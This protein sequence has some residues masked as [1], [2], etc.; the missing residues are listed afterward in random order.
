M[1]LDG[2]DKQNA[3]TN[4]LPLPVDVVADTAYGQSIT[5]ETVALYY[6]DSGVVTADAGQAAGT[7]VIAK[8]AYSGVMDSLGAMVGN[9]KDTSLAWTTNTVLPIADIQPCKYSEIENPSNATLAQIAADV[10]ANFT[11][12]QWCLDHRNGIIYGKKK[13]TGTSDTAAYKVSTQ[14]VAGGTSVAATV[15]LT[16][17]TDILDVIVQDAAFGTAT[18]GLAVFGKYQATPT[19]YTDGDATPILLDANGRVVL[20]SDIEIGAVELKDGATDTRATI[21]AANTARTTATTVL[22]TQPIDA[23]GNVLGR[24]AANTA[25]TTGTLV[26]PVQV[27]D[28]AGNAV[29]ITAANTARTTGT[30]TLPTQPID[31]AGLVLGRDAANTARTTG[32]KVAPSQLVG[33]D[34]TV[35]PTGSLLTN[36]PFA[37]ITDGTSNL[38]LGT[39]TTKT[40]PSAINDGTTMAT[41]TTGTIKALNVAISDGATIPAVLT[42]T[43][44]TLATSIHDGT[45]LLTL[46]T[47]TK[48]T[49]PVQLSDGTTDQAVIAT[50]QSAKEDISSVGGVAVPAMNAAFGTTTPLVPIAG[51]FMATPTTYD[52][53][54]AVPLALDANGRM[55]LSSDI[56]LGAVEM[57]DGATDAR[58]TIDAANTARTTATTVLATQPIDA[59]GNVLGRTAANVARTTATLVDPVEIVDAAGNVVNITA[60]N[61]ARTT[62][63]LV[64]PTQVVDEAGLVLGRDAANTAR[65]TGTKVAPSQLV[66]A[67]GTVPPT[68]SLLTNAPFAKIT[69]GISNLTL[70]VGTTKTVPAELN[71][72]TTKIIFGTGT[73]KTVPVAISDGTTE[74]DVIA[75]IN[76][77]KA[78]VSSVA[79]TATAVNVG[80]ASAGA[81]RIALARDARGNSIPSDFES[82]QDFAV[83]YTS[84]VT[85]TCSGAS[86]TI[87][88]ANCTVLYVQVKPTGSTWGARYVNGQDGIS[89]IAASNVITIAGAGTPFAASDTYRVGLSAQ[90]K[91]HT[92]ASN[93]TRAEEVNPLSLQVV[94]ES[95]VDT[96]NVAA[97]QQYYPSS[98]GMAMLGYKN[99][100]LTGKY[101]DGDAT[102]TTLIVQGTNDS[103][104][105]NGTWVSIQGQIQGLS[106]TVT[107]TVSGTAGVT[108]NPGSVCTSVVTA[109]A[110]TMTLAWDFDNLN[111][112]YIRVGLL[113]GDATNTVEIFARRSA[114]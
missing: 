4:R 64:L 79:G 25:R 43:T 29:N 32:T 114:M 66:G 24:D 105:T 112:R 5:G 16:D 63:T 34:G 56:E 99:F 11:N 33:A 111:Y 2:Y 85:I 90:K 55:I 89:L 80:V 93:S 67:D 31:E 45:T 82:P 9:D 12:G 91:A 110:Q 94:E 62:A 6:F 100:S 7:V 109:T 49:M 39:G 65:T 95:L 15:K 97:S 17:G 81:Q 35:P 68:G 44:K 76:A 75:T 30:L 70:G 50:I 18:K 14:T 104:A 73:Q 84:N 59:A 37:K 96:T 69:D 78:D 26:N 108:L 46:N 61:T 54:D 13:T 53:G 74:V 103:D 113:P 92:A 88:D 8:L 51:K 47:G 101:I 21:N 87:D 27:V 77:I 19:T 23:A 106:G 1:L 48:K 42:G 10:T 57:K 20:S 38:T 22:A 58:A 83:A 60:A 98:L 3:V 36:A 40:V 52:E 28:A 107:G 102:T 86:F 71:D 72:G 41:V